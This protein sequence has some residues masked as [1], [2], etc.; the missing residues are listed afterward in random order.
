MTNAATEIVYV[1]AAYF[2]AA[3]IALGISV[4]TLLENRRLRRQLA[5]IEARGLKRRSAAA[6]PQA[7]S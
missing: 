3:A 7:K 4:A 6:A 1:Y 5:D 2:A